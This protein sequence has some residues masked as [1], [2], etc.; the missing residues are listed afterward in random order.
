MTLVQVN[1]SKIFIKEVE[2]SSNSRHF[3][4]QI[5][6]MAVQTAKMSSENNLNQ[7]KYTKQ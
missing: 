3:F 1:G 6:I 7:T 4:A 5:E 2:K